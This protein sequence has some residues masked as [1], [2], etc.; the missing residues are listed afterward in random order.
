MI[1]HRDSSDEMAKLR[2]PYRH[3]RIIGAYL[4]TEASGKQLHP[5]VILT[6]DAEITQPEDF[7]PRRGGE[8]F[9]VVIGVSTKYA[10]Y[11]DPYIKLPY[12]ESG[13]PVTKLTKDSAAIIG[14]YD[15]VHI[16]GERRFWGGDVPIGIMTEINHQSR[17]DIARRI[18]KEF[19]VMSE[20][21]LLLFGDD[22][23]G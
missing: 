6:P 10:V 20:I 12:H 15:I 23:G 22:L 1:F 14:W 5:A 4:R 2:F 11:A 17:I 3:G 7:D 21:V 19:K 16:D 9:V 8:N 18:G 13:H